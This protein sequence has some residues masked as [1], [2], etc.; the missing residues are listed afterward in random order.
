MLKNSEVSI[1]DQVSIG[2]ARGCPPDCPYSNTP[3]SVCIFPYCEP[4]KPSP[5][6]INEGNT[7]SHIVEIGIEEQS[8]IVFQQEGN[9]PISSQ[10]FS[11]KPILCPTS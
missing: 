9:T 5:K 2:M 10:T 4:P 11:N 8:R 6:P 7:V 3:V 1:V